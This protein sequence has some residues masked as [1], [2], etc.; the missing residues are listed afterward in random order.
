M[1]CL[2]SRCTK[3]ALYV[4]VTLSVFQIAIAANAQRLPQTVKPEHYALTLAPDLKAAAFTGKESMDV[5]VLQP[6]DAI[7]LNAAEIKFQSVTAVVDGKTLTAKVSEEG[8]GTEKPVRCEVTVPICCGSVK[9]AGSVIRA[10]SKTTRS[11][12][13]PWAIRPRSG[14][15]NRSATWN[16]ALCTAASRDSAP[17]SRT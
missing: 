8:S 6:V 14:M 2:F 17:R 3:S 16:V 13:Q 15:P 7:T 10:G 1:R 5:D 12:I 4:A 11:A 9:V